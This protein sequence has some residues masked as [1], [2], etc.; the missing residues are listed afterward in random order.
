MCQDACF[1]PVLWLF[2][3]HTR[4]KDAQKGHKRVETGHSNG[5]RGQ[6]SRKCSGNGMT[7]KRAPKEPAKGHGT[8]KQKC[9]PDAKWCAFCSSVPVPPV[10]CVL[11]LIRSLDSAVGVGVGLGFSS[12]LLPELRFPLPIGAGPV[13]ACIGPLCEKKLGVSTRMEP[14]SVE[15]KIGSVGLGWVQRVISHPKHFVIILSGPW[16]GAMTHNRRVWVLTAGK[17]WVK[18]L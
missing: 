4:P 7:P 11:P 6:W 12:V 16:F 8:R 13:H 10:P 3:H 1:W 14:K 2:G 17:T 9:A 15:T 18:R 5:R